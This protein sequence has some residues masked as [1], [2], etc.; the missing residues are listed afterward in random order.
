LARQRIDQWLWQA[1]FFR[2]RTLAHEACERGRVRLNGSRI[3]KAHRGVQPGDILTLAWA[4][5]IRVVQV[6]GLAQRR[7]SPREALTLYQEVPAETAGAPAG[8]MLVQPAR[9]RH[10]EQ[11][12]EP[13]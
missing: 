4:D 6:N 3:E 10:S 2:T 12:R 11:G 8:P 13:C 5:R 1:R 9:A 7:V